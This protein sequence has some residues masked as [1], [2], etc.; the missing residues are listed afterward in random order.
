M[1]ERQDTGELELAH[2]GEQYVFALDG[3][4]IRVGSRTGDEVRW[5][6]TGVP[7]SD[8]G[9]EAQRAI[10]NGDVTCPALL[11]ALKGIAAGIATRGG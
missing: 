6:A 4:Q 10:A 7:L 5:M 11:I 9:G 2:G 3:D 1:L 8:L